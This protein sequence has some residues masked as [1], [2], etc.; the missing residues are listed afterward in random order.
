MRW[1]LFSVLL[2]S[3]CCVHRRDVI[4]ITGS[5]KPDNI[6]DGEVTVLYRAEIY[7]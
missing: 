6:K 5:A 7:R 3:G 1:I 2:F 4:E